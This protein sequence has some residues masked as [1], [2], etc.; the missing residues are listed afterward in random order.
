M[1]GSALRVLYTRKTGQ[2]YKKKLKRPR[3]K[4]IFLVKKSIKW[5]K[6]AF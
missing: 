2:N 5:P 1:R 4:R 3:K 6:E